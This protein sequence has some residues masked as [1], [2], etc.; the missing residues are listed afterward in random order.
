MTAAIFVSAVFLIGYVADK[1]IRGGV[2]TAFAGEGFWKA[3]YYTML[4]THIVAAMVILPL[5]LWTWSRALKKDF[6]RHRRWAKFTFPL[7]YYVSVTGVLVYLF[8]YQ[9]F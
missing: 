7:W 5:V 4:I 2:H 3:I 6:S 1:I 8:L 9:L